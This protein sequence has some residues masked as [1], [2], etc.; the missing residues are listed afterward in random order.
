MDKTRWITRQYA[1]TFIPPELQNT[2]NA[3][4]QS[5]KSFIDRMAALA[6]FGKFLNRE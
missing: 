1:D 4:M 5:S 2:T 3:A 6:G